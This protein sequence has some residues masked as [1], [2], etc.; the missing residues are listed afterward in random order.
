MAA[1]VNCIPR[2]HNNEISSGIGQSISCQI[3]TSYKLVEDY[4]FLKSNKP[5]GFGLN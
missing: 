2:L 3:L 5:L 4:V 1:Y